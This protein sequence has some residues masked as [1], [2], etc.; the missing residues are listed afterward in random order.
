V[1]TIGLPSMFAYERSVFGTFPHPLYTVSDLVTQM[2][3]YLVEVGIVS[4]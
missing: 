2:T 1:K 4:Q 3:R